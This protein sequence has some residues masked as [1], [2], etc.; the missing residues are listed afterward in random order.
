MAVAK[1]VAFFARMDAFVRWQG[2]GC[3]NNGGCDVLVLAAFTSRQWMAHREREGGGGERSNEAVAMFLRGR[4]AAD[5]T[6]KGGGGTERVA[7]GM[8]EA[9]NSMGEGGG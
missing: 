9:D 6:T 2:G 4:W 8:L 3:V 5:D 7:R 1:A